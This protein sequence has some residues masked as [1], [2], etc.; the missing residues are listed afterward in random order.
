[1][2]TF[3]GDITVEA[4]NVDKVKLSDLLA[5]QGA[6]AKIQVVGIT[7]IAFDGDVDQFIT[8]HGD[9]PAMTITAHNNAIEAGRKTRQALFELFGDRIKKAIEGVD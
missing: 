1:M 5:Q 8:D 7:N 4:A 6:N 2:R 9:V 3:T